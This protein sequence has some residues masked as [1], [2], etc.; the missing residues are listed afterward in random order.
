MTSPGPA[1][2]HLGRCIEVA[3]VTR[4]TPA[5]V[6]D[7]WTDP[8]RLVEWFADRVEGSLEEGRIA[9]SF[10]RLK[11]TMAFRVVAVTVGARLLL[12]SLDREPRRLELL[13]GGVPGGTEVRVIDSG[14]S[15]A[16]AEDEDFVA[17]DSGWRIALPILRYYVEF[18][19]NQPRE[20]F[21]V[22]RPA[23]F[24]PSLLSRLYREPDGLKEWLSDGGSL[25]TPGGRVHLA[26]KD[27]ETLRGDMLADTGTELAMAWDEIAGVLQFKTCVLPGEVG[28]RS[29]YLHGWGWG[30]SGD[31]ARHVERRL[32]EAVDRL[33]RALDQADADRSV[34]T[35]T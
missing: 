11:S 20:S 33:E 34:L 9:W 5:R 28:T 6:W 22:L 31:R 27:G 24:T 12:E 10:E 21:F 26:L 32:S 1:S 16:G 18:H 15:N 35:S 2:H 4:A 17:A 19:F 23:R 25:G 30:I 8:D 7:A 29:V 14:F 3:I 13:I